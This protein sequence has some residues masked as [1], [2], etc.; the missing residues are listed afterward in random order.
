MTESIF[1]DTSL[2]LAIAIAISFIVQIFRQPLIIAYIITGIVAGPLFLNLINTNQEFFDVFAKIGVILL[3]FLV[4]LS[5]NIDYLRRIGKVA[6]ITGVGQAVFTSFLGFLILISLGFNRSAA[7][8]LAISIT[9][10]S[11]IIIMKLLSDKREQRTVYGRYTIGLMLVQDMIAI[12]LMILLPSIGS[13]ESIM[14]SL[15]MLFVKNNRF[16]SS[17]LFFYPEYFYR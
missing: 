6:A 4:G 16:D 15:L 1:I 11:T 3:L 5:L 14:A 12:A 9:F 2:V 13:G 10:S 17:G 8:Y 7:V